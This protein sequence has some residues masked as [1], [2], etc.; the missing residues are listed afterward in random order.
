MSHFAEN[1]FYIY[2]KAHSLV[3]FM[4]NTVAGHPDYLLFVNHCMDM[5]T[6]MMTGEDVS[7]YVEWFTE[8]FNTLSVFGIVWDEEEFEWYDK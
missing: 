1:D 4:K 3:K 6:K 8:W 2:Y 7:Y 5:S